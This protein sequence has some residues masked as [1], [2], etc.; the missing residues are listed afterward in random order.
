MSKANFGHFRHIWHLR[1]QLK[2]SSQNL[3]DRFTY[4]AWCSTYGSVL[5]VIGDGHESG[6]YGSKKRRKGHIWS[7]FVMFLS[8]F[9]V[10]TG[11]KLNA[12]NVL[13]TFNL[14]PVFTGFSFTTIHE[15]QW[16]RGRNR[17]FL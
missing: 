2:R 15:S 16:Y 14:R 1:K 8:G 5:V 3:S 13:Y 6:G 7:I 12:H 9:P 10:D 17:A 4:I 11:H